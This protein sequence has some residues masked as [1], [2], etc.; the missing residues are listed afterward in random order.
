MSLFK[1]PTEIISL[2]F[3]ETSTDTKDSKFVDHL[4]IDWPVAK[5]KYASKADVAGLPC[6]D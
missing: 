2:L 4:Y 6:Q 5:Q 1:V 3:N